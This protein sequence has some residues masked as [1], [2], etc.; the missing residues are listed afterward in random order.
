MRID[1]WS[2]VSCPWC[3]ITKRTFEMALSAS[4]RGDAHVVLHP[5]QIDGE[6]PAEPVPMLDW[7]AGK[8]GPER[9]ASMDKEVSAAGPRHGI[10]FRNATGFAVNTL[11]AQRLLWWAG[12]TRGRQSQSRLEELLF[13]AYFTQSADLSDHEVLLT[14]VERAGLD[15][16]GAARLLAS[17]EAVAEVR[18]ELRRARDLGITVVPRVEIA[19]GPVIEGP[20]EDPEV[21]LR[22][23][24]ASAE[25]PSEPRR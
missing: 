8:Y 16:G 13:A 9:A 24:T 18:A 2:D 19:G 3:Y 7:L 25:A 1:I 12:R 20:Q 21:F 15:R 11:D 23:L 5:F 10:A 17:D 14:R 22:A 6:R 4:G